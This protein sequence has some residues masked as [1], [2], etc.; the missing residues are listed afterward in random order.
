MKRL[1]TLIELLVVI[2]IIAI[3]AALLLPA[4]G[5]AREKARQTSCM[6]NMKQMALA[7][8]MYRDDNKD[9][10]S[11]WLSTLYR[12]YMPEEKAYLCP[13]HEGDVADPHPYDSGA[14]DFC[15]DKE[16]TT[17]VHANPNV[18]TGDGQVK[19]VDYLYQMNDADATS[20]KA[21]FVKSGHEANFDDCVTMCD[22][23]EAQLKYGDGYN[24]RYDASIFPVISCF[25]HAK[26]RDG[27]TG[28]VENYAPV[29]QISYAGNFFLSRVRWEKGVWTP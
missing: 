21:W 26:Y 9:A 29:L 16:G 1:F 23:K 27:S 7:E 22:F 6:N 11:Y 17:G 28:D 10:W 15:Y 3:L 18:G 12:G 20:K 19:R 14:V 8:I 5:K 2:A 24:D 4:L 13:N 25:H